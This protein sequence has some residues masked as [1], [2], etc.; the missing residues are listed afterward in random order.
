MARARA[1]LAGVR[2]D[3]ERAL[4][5][6]RLG[7]DTATVAKWPHGLA[8]MTEQCSRTEVYALL[9]DVDA[10]VPEL[11]RCL[12][13]PSSPSVAALALEPGIARWLNDPRVRAVTGRPALEIRKGE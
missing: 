5:E 7:T 4:A 11:R 2:G 10:M 9:N 3:R 6:I 13:H 1:W 8:A 12:G